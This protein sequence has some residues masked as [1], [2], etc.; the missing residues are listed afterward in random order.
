[1]SQYM[2]IRDTTLLATGPKLIFGME[3]MGL[4]GGPSVRQSV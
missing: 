1:M 4:G 3:I 2:T